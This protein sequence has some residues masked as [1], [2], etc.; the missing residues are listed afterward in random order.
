MGQNL[1][2]PLM[3]SLWDRSA[4]FAEARGLGREPPDP[5]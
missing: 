3:E 5:V 1:S 2:S 4:T